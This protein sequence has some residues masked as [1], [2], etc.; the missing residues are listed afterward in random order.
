[1]NLAN[2]YNV[3]LLEEDA[4]I[5]KTVSNLCNEKSLRLS[6]FSSNVELMDSVM[7]SPPCCI[8]AAN[9]NDQAL[10]LMGDLASRNQN[11]PV[12]I[13]GEH[14]DV[15]SA[16]AAIKAG[17]LDYIEKPTVYGRL[18]EQLN[19]VKKYDAISASVSA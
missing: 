4:C 12:I 9:N 16:V 17:A 6:C 14:N 13:L 19:E 18:A 1:M 3:Y 2:P 15:A 10:I 7:T 8:I 11:I 5:T